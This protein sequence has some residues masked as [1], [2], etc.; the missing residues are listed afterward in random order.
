MNSTRELLLP[1]AQIELIHITHFTDNGGGFS[2]LPKHVVYPVSERA[3][4]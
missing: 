2:R 4:V 3:G 1:F